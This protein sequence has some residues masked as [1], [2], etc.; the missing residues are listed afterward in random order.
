LRL[1]IGLMHGRRLERHLDD[2]VGRRE[3]GLIGE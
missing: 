1:D 3:T 2:L